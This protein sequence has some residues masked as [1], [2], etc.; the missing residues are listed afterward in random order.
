MSREKRDVY[1]YCRENPLI[2]SE[3][4]KIG[5]Q[6]REIRR[7]CEKNGIKVTDWIED[8]STLAEMD[9]RDGIE[10]LLT[11]APEGSA[12]IVINTSVLWFDGDGK[13]KIIKS[14][15]KKHMT[16]ISVE[17]PDFTIDDKDPNRFLLN[18]ISEIVNRYLEYREEQ[19]IRNGGDAE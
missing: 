18:G 15:L 12:V 14:L 19:E 4:Y 7:Y 17:Q 11:E 8:T 13:I 10:F 1:A 2:N 9:G 3:R 16:V 6:K 5:T